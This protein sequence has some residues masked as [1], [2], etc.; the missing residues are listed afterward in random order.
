LEKKLNPRVGGGKTMPDFVR[1]MAEL[2][3]ANPKKIHEAVPANMACGRSK[4]T[5]TFHPRVVDGLPEIDPQQASALIG[6][7]VFIDVRRSDEFNGELGHI[8][9]AKLV[10]LGDDLLRFLENGDRSDEIVFVC[11]SGGRSGQAT[12]QSVTM[13]YK[14]TANMIG[15]MIRWNELHLA[16]EIDQGGQR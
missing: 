4:D 8:P 7:V 10:T 2:K 11:R 14:Y 16:V 13:G 9:G 12:A 15:G 6:R 5:R 3:L 1:I